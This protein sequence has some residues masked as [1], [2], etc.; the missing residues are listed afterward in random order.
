[1]GN[2]LCGIKFLPAHAAT[3][4]AE[5]GAVSNENRFIG[6]WQF[7]TTLPTGE[8]ELFSRLTIFENNSYENFFTGYGHPE[9]ITGLYSIK[10]DKLILDNGGECTIKSDNPN[11]LQTSF[12]EYTRVK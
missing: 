12:G 6:V 1:M 4:G 11:I 3:S 7:F 10:N 9:T 5:E 2:A 8:E